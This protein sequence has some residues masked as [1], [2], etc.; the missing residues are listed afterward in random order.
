MIGGS[1]IDNNNAATLLTPAQADAAA[2]TMNKSDDDWTYTAV[3]DPTG[4]GSSFITVQDESGK[5]L[6]KI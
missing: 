6:G 4:T 5:Y 1:R 2:A 3:H